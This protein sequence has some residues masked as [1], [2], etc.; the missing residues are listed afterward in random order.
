M[1]IEGELPP[2]EDPRTE[3]MNNFYSYMPEGG[4]RYRD[5]KGLLDVMW[6][7][8]RP[9]WSQAEDKWPPNMADSIKSM[10]VKD[11][12]LEAIDEFLAEKPRI[13]GWWED[14][15]RAYPDGV[16]N[17]VREVVESQIL[18]PVYVAMRKKF[19]REQLTA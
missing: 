12:I 13:A 19:N 5:G 3:V 18:R 4:Y 2:V 9:Y 14:W 15:C 17:A 16:K 7:K 10:R 11:E 8:C 6:D 1:I